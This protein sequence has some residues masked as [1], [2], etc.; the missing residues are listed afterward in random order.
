SNEVIYQYQS[1]GNFEQALKLSLAIDRNV[2]DPGK[3]FIYRKNGDN[4]E[5]LV[6]QVY[7]RDA[8]LEAVIY[9]RDLGSFKLAYDASFSGT[10]LVP[11]DYALKQNYPNPFNP[12]TTIQYD[13]ANDGHVRILIYNILGQRIRELINENQLAGS[14]KRTIWDGRDQSG[15]SVASGVYIYQITSREYFASKRMLLIK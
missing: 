9:T 4:W 11:N 7:D 3:Y 6:T 10:N 12:S 13:L 5:Q 15:K 8:K 14:N 2:S 1:D